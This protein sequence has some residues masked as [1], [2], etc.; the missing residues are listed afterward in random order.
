MIRR[1]SGL[2]HVNSDRLFH[3]VS[4]QLQATILSIRGGESKFE[5]ETTLDSKYI[6]S[7][8]GYFNNLRV[9]AAVLMSI[10]MKEMYQLQSSPSS[11]M[12][13]WDREHRVDKSKRWRT[14]RYTYLLLMILS[15]CLEVHTIFVAT[16]V[17]TQLAT[18][19]SVVPHEIDLGDKDLVG[20]LFSMRATK[21]A[22]QSMIEFLI[23]NFEFEYATVR[24][25]FVTGLLSF[26]VAQALR[27][28]YALRKYK[29]LSLSGMCCLLCVATGMLTYTNANTIT[30]GGY[31]GLLR[32]QIWLS[33]KFIT[34]RIR[35]GPLSAVTAMLAVLSLTYAILGMISPEFDYFEVDAEVEEVKRTWRNR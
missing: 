11:S 3:N 7:A 35:A 1:L 21:D 10:V 23:K 24:L 4:S 6:Q 25:H 20:G 29:E 31:L 16:Q 34:T 13:K 32:R 22:H 12:R 14:L 5:L 2:A 33:F 8:I 15:F 27:V 28:R 18:A 30:Y 19:Q 17:L 9:P 26:T